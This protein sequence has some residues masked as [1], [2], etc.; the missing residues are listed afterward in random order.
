VAGLA[1][2]NWRER[3]ALVIMWDAEDGR[4]LLVFKG[5]TKQLHRVV[6]SADGSRLTSYGED[7]VKVWDTTADQRG[8]FLENGSGGS[9]AW[10]PDGKLVAIAA[11]WDDDPFQVYL[12]DS[13]TGRRVRTLQ[14][15]TGG[16]YSI[17]FSS[18]GRLAGGGGIWGGS[19]SQ[20]KI[21]CRSL[22]GRIT[23]HGRFITSLDILLQLAFVLWQEQRL[24]VRRPAPT[25][26]INREKPA[27]LRFFIDHTVILLVK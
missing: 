6:F 9:L 2:W 22:L 24:G 10:S 14:G 19:S 1:G 12:W 11:E 20:V 23:F 27:T 25:G 15:R 3:P 5:H 13:V 18:D 26:P 21:W 8:V 16:V 7:G 4:V 17:A